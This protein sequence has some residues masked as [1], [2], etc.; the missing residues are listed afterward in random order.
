MDARE[1]IDRPEVD[2]TAVFA[3]LTE[4]TA[5]FH[6]E[7]SP[8]RVTDVLVVFAFLVGLSL[9]ATGPAFA[10]ALLRQLEDKMPSASEHARSIV[11]G[12]LS[13]EGDGS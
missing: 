5:Q 4:W 13:R 7:F 11:Q 9:A 8:A 6:D 3:R 1:Q 2:P 10:E 12:M